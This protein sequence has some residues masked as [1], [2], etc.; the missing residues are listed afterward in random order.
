MKER[1]DG[2]TTKVYDVRNNF[3]HYT[4]S[5]PVSQEYISAYIAH[6]TVTL[7]MPLSMVRFEF[8]ER[9][10]FLT[11]RRVGN[12]EADHGQST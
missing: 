1:T 12:Y 5:E 6:C 10:V 7:N 2:A 3:E 4:T 11:N 8:S 9:T